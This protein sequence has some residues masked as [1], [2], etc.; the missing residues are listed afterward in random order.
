MAVG[1]TWE[2]DET[3][4][5]RMG[6]Y[7]TEI[8]MRLIMRGLRGKKDPR[9]LDIGA[10]S[11]R[12]AIPVITQGYGNVVGLE[13]GALQLK[14]LQQN[15]RNSVPVVLADAMA[16][17]FGKQSFDALL[18]LQLVNYL[19]SCEGFFAECH[20]I[21]KPE[22][23]LLVNFSNSLS[24][25][26]F[27]YKM[28]RKNGTFYKLSSTNFKKAARNSGF[29]VEGVYGFRWLPFG[30]NSNNISIPVLT[31]IERLLSPITP[32]DICP[33]VFIALKKSEVSPQ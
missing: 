19:P 33:W 20:R 28:I 13:K 12:I 15:T 6:R 31:K 8:E 10:G 27:V 3:N 26:A 2:W 21:L 9:I 11:G 16:L 4:A 5:T 18:A 7:L 22:G 29:N 23:I 14:K 25:F 1:D 30:R 17:P 32:A 24:P